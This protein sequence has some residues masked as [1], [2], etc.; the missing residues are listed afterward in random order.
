MYDAVGE[1]ISV[2]KQVEVPPR[3]NAAYLVVVISDG[4]ENYSK[5]Y[6][7]TTIRSAVSSCQETGKWTFVYIGANQDLSKISKDLNIPTANM[8]AF[9]ATPEGLKRAT[10]THGTALSDYL[11]NRTLGVTQSANFYADSTGTSDDKK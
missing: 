2:L 6:N 9:N 3:T 8:L 4:M 10:Y 7:S 5:E 11:D 1:T